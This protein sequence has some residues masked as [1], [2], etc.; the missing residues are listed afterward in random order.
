MKT[1]DFSLLV[2]SGGPLHQNVFFEKFDLKKKH[3]KFCP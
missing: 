1:A 3:A 2:R